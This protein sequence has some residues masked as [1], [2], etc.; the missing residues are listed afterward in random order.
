MAIFHLGKYFVEIFF[1]DLVANRGLKACGGTIFIVVKNVF[2]G[3]EEK[4]FRNHLE[5]VY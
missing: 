3:T 4:S 5:N 2:D 1:F